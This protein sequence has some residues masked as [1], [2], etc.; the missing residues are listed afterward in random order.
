MNT[1]Y[2]LPNEVKYCKECVISNQRPS[3]FPEFKHTRERSG[4][5]Y[6]NFDE[7]GVCD[8]CISAEKKWSSTKLID[9]EK[10]ESEFNKIIQSIDRSQSYD[11]VVPVS[12]GKDSTWQVLRAKE[13]HNLKVLAVTFDQ[14]DQT[15][16][17]VHNL[18]ILKEIGVDHI[19]FTLNPNLLKKLVLQGLKQVG[20]PYWVNH[21]GMFTI[22]TIIAVNFN[23]PLVI[24]GENPQ[25]EYG[26]PEESRKPQPMNKR[27]RQEFAGLRGLRE[28]DM[29][30][31]DI[32][33]RDIQTLKFP[34]V[35]YTYRWEKVS[36][37]YENCARI[38]FFE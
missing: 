24:Y 31:D 25:F 4:A 30:D 17:G 23:I 35:E 14:F 18:N 8:A 7:N 28:E 1:M 26:G 6:M 27:W 5:K 34:D 38:P 21:V 20:D 33:Y 12:G 11:C 37:A 29:V 19:H 9:W 13:K 36:C 2:G 22:P 32:S 3:S 15:E 10:R 16:T